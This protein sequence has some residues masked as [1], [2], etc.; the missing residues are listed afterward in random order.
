MIRDLAVAT[1]A[2]WSSRRALGAGLWHFRVVPTAP[3]Q[4]TFQL[5]G[6]VARRCESYLLLIGHARI[7]VTDG[8]NPSPCEM[9]PLRSVNRIKQ[10]GAKNEVQIAKGHT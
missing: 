5:G 10:N 1:A 8:V 7:V 6:C 3:H 4:D 2:S 9:S